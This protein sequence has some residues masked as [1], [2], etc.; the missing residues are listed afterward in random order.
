MVYLLKSF[1]ARK[2]VERRWYSRNLV[3]Q[4]QQEPV[5][6]LKGSD[7]GPGNMSRGGRIRPALWESWPK[8]MEFSDAGQT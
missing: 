5:V 8:M 7:Y 6:E 4:R 1:G 3:S 2:G